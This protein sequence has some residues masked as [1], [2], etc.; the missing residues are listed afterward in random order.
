MLKKTNKSHVS[1]YIQ[2]TP[3]ITFAMTIITIYWNDIVF[4]NCS[5][6]AMDYIVPIVIIYILF[7]YC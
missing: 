1:N 7:L 5:A 6:I 2:K 4:K 3:N